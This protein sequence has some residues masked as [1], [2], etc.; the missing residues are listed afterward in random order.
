MLKCRTPEN[1]ASIYACPQCG[2]V[3]MVYHSCK[4]RFCPKCGQLDINK[5]A[6]KMVRSML[7]IKHHHIVFTVPH[8]LNNLFRYNEKLLYGLLM[9][10]S[11]KV[12]TDWFRVKHNLQP[13]IMCVLHTFGSNLQYHVHTH[14]V[15]SA[16]GLTFDFN[17]LVEFKG[18]YLVNKN[19]LVNQFR[20][21][22][23]GEL[24]KLHE[25][26][27]LNYPPD[28]EPPYFLSYI[29]NLNGQ[30]WVAFIGKRPLKNVEDIVGYIARYTRRACISE[31]KIEKVTADEITIRYKDYKSLTGGDKEIIKRVTYNWEKFLDLL[32]QHIPHKH[33]RIVT[34][35]GC[36][37]NRNIKR[38]PEEFKYQ[39]QNAEANKIESY[40]DYL[41][42]SGKEKEMKCTFCNVEYILI[43][44]AF[45]PNK[46]QNLIITESDF[47]TST[48]LHPFF[49]QELEK[50]QDFKLLTSEELQ[51]LVSI[52]NQTKQESV[53]EQA[54]FEKSV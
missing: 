11:C 12:L 32:F 53:T 19:W 50:E 47:N 36:Y 2:E 38:I 45:K 34:Y 24:I 7:D 23:E 28:L 3:I 9:R 52:I 42:Q 18:N 16:G 6:N 27:E 8:K 1:G 22:F 13:G 46:M 14:L 35:S 43:S 37:N 15:V 20:H 29:K 10:I 44:R 54:T 25:N 39:S 17:E 40:K 49:R 41:L 30:K 5:W 51:S 48:K 21:E 33:F 4:H 26:G 31:Y